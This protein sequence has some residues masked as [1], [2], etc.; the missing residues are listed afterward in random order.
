MLLSAENGLSS[1]TAVC[2]EGP[3]KGE[4]KSIHL[5]HATDQDPDNSFFKRLLWDERLM[6][7]CSVLLV[8]K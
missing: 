3:K 1:E 5:Q 6:S 4:V 7:K 2:I 8:A